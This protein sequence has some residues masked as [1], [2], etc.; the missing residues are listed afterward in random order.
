MTDTE[1]S[2][3]P[4]DTPKPPN[5]YESWT[6][7][8]IAI[9]TVRGNVNDHQMSYIKAELAALRAKAAAYDEAMGALRL[10]KPTCMTTYSKQHFGPCDLCNFAT[11]EIASGR[12]KP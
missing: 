9:E 10:L 5:G 11:R 1:N 2:D 8:L 4:S 6:D 12:F 7:W 3:R